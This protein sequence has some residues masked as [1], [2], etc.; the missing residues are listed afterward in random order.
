MSS[1]KKKAKISIHFMKD[2]FLVGES[3]I[4]NIEIQ[5][6][7]TAL[8]QGISIEINKAENWKVNN[9][10]K[11]NSDYIKR[12]LISIN[13]DLKKVNNLKIIDNNAI[14]PIGKTL[15]PFNFHIS[16]NN[17]PCFEFPDPDKRSSIRY[18][19]SVVIVSSDIIGNE[20]MP[21]SLLSRPVIEPEKKLSM[22]IRQ[23]IKKWKVI[24][25]GNTTLTVTLPEN[26]F[27]YS[28]I[29][30]LKIFID[31]SK[32][33][34][35]TREY[36]V[37]LRRIITYKNKNGDIK[38]SFKKKILRERVR[39]EV[40]PG[41]KNNFE[42][43]LSFREK[44][45]YK[46]YNYNNDTNPYKI[47]INKINYYMPSVNGQLI[48]CEYNIKISLYFESFVDKDH[49]PRVRIPIYLV[50]QLPKD[51]QLKGQAQNNFG[52]NE[53]NINISK[54]FNNFYSEDNYNSIHKESYY[55]DI[56]KNAS[57][58]DINKNANYNEINKN[59]NNNEINKNSN[60][61][62]IIKN[63]NNN[64]IIKNSNN[65]EINEN[66]NPNNIN[67]FLY[68]DNIIIE[69]EDDNSLPSFEMIEEARKQKLI[70]SENDNNFKYDKFVS[71]KNEISRYSDYCAP[72]PL[73][74][75]SDENSNNNNNNNNV[76]NNVYP[77]FEE[78]NNI[79]IQENNNE[80]NDN[81]KFNKPGNDNFN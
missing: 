79:I 11:D 1:D 73:G 19:F 21:L 34:L 65:N 57:Y 50:H 64:E 3:I 51:Y 75:S 14:L 80:N 2:S 31:N 22:S 35:T 63:S 61:N 37:G 67:D 7:V 32:G 70:S 78:N 49:R 66:Q 71:N 45:L 5:T 55:S 44:D 41:S 18:F 52:N 72:V 24:D 15:I 33:E 36:K 27:K 62:E 40:G 23:S 47:D 8:I 74:F 43:N 59:S 46:I 4:G 60:N 9:N 54:S 39:A 20:N 42:Y 58:I 29:C 69:E 16:E 25:Q 17:C 13:L 81:M 6:N 53:N 26:N 38:Y 30:L 28:D 76:N 10:D 68:N 77:D 12:K 48:S 56:K